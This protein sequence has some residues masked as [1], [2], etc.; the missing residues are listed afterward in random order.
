MYYINR[1]TALPITEK[2]KQKEWETI[3]T[4][5]KNNGYPI[6]MIHGLKTK[7]IN[8]EK[9]QKQTQTLQQQET[10]TPRNK[11][12]TFTYFSPLVRKVTNLFKQTSLKIVFRATNTI[13][14]LVAKQTHNDPSSIYERKCK[15]CNKVYLGQSGRTI[16]VRF[17]EHII[18]NNS[19]SAYILDNKHGYGTKEDTLELLKACQKGT[20]M[21]CWEALYMQVFHQKKILIDEQQVSE[22]NPPL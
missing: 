8:R 3:L 1:L 7:L 5:A 2:S 14:Q 15:T 9:K 16:G 12:I 6:N 18:Y 20:Y 10:I 11:W 21:D 22:T 17:K 19:I 4:I 13:Q